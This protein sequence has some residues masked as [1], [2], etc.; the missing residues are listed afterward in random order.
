MLFEQRFIGSRILRELRRLGYRGGQTAL[1]AYLAALKA[2]RGEGQA[3]MRYRQSRDPVERSQWQILWRLARGE[4][5][6]S[7]AAGTG[8]SA[9]WIYAVVR[10]YNAAGAAGVGDRRH[11]NP[12]AVPLLPPDQQAALRA[13]LAHPAPDGG[14]WTG[15]KVARWMADRLGRPVGPQR[16]WEYLRRLGFT[17]QV[18]RPRHA[19]ADPVAQEAFKR[20]A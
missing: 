6:A 14:V 16:G 5:T 9:T 20:G 19:Q 15:P 11:A 13:A 10:R 8:Y 2:A 1:Y 7:V 18:P 3:V 12:G 17:P 4:P